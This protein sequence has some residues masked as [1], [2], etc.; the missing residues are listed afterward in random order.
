MIKHE[1]EVKSICLLTTLVIVVFLNL[2]IN[3]RMR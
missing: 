2:I 1:I 3:R